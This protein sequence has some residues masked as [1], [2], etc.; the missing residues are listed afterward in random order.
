MY[1]TRVVRALHKHVPLIK[2]LGPRDKLHKEPKETASPS[3]TPSDHKSIIAF[4]Q[5]PEKYKRK[6]PSPEEIDAIEHGGADNIIRYK[7]YFKF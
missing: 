3:N 1:P 4:S 2:F 7:G 5:L 6:G